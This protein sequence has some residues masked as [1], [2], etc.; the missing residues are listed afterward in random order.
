MSTKKI[1]TVQEV[2][3]LLNEFLNQKCNNDY[4]TEVIPLNRAEKAS[5]IIKVCKG[6]LFNLTESWGHIEASNLHLYAYSDLHD[7]INV[8][9][10]AN[11]MIPL[12]FINTLQEQ[13][14]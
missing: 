3:E 8:L 5:S 11:E 1:K 2:K 14:K 6:A 12:D 13:L 10:V 4:R 9:E 7:I